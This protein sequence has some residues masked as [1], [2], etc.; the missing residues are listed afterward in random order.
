VALV[1]AFVFVVPDAYQE[2]LLEGTSQVVGQS[3][4]R[5]KDVFIKQVEKVQ[6]QKIQAQQIQTQEHHKLLAQLIPRLFLRIGFFLQW[7]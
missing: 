6:I 7:Y 3:I 2:Q 1:L 5:V 4:E